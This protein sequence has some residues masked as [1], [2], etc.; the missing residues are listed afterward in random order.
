MQS[1]HLAGAGEMVTLLIDAEL[2]L[3]DKELSENIKRYPLARGGKSF[4][5]TP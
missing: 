5:Y 2:G 4:S 1:V 3:E